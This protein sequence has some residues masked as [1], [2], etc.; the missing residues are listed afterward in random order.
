[1]PTD[2]HPAS[3]PWYRAAFGPSYLTV[4]RKRDEADARGLA[5]LLERMD[6][7]V[8]DRRVLDVGCGPGRHLRVLEDAGARACGIDLSP[9][10]LA[11]ARRRDPARRL[12][13]ADMR[14]LP[15]RDGSFDLALFLFTTFGYFETDDAHARL[16]GEVRRVLAPGGGLLIDTLNPVVLRR[17]LVPVSDR[18][19]DSVRLL[20]RRTFD[21][22]RGRVEKAVRL[23]NPSTGDVDAWTESVR[24]WPEAKLRA[25]VESAGFARTRTAGAFDGRPFSPETSERILLVAERGDG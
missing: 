19:V 23:E 10:L 18:L 11:E 20:E 16:L 1:M 8:A 7:R 14:A 21:S 9:V 4:Y 22:A 17:T 5:L 2:S 24:V 13:R 15:F 6:V 12:V 3:V 25:L